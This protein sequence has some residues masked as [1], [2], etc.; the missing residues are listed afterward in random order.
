M[1]RFNGT[2][3]ID[4]PN[5]R[6]WDTA[7]QSYIPD[8]VGEEIITIRVEDNVQTYEVLYGDNPVIRMGYTAR[9]DATEWAPYTVREIIAAPGAD[10]AAAAAEFRQRIG[11]NEGSNAR[12][13]QVGRPYG[14]IRLVYVDERTHYRIGKTEDGSP[15]NAMLRRLA[16][17]GRSYLT[18]LMDAE[19]IVS[20]IRPFIRL[21]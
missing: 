3:K 20:R 12:N 9:F 4:L 13:F 6:K 8:A 21:G 7:S 18:S 11:A 1:S 15:Q 10:P 16:E 2:W 17:D 14:L 5:A 19:G